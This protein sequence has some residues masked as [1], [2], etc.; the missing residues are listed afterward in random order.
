MVCRRHE[1]HEAKQKRKKQLYA[2]GAVAAR[3]LPS[4]PKFCDHFFSL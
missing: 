1:A 4:L 3:A 2:W